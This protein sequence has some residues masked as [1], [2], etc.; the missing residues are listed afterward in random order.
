MIK[1]I[2]QVIL[3]VMPSKMYVVF[4]MVMVYGNVIME[5]MFVIYLNAKMNAQRD[6]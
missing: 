6:L 3:M 5:P 1:L 4:V 2:R